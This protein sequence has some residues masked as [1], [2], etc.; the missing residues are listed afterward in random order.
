[1]PRFKGWERVRIDTVPGQV[2]TAPVIVSASRATDIPAWYPEWL[3]EGLKR[4][5]IRWNNPFSGREAYISFEK[6][7]AFVLW[8]KNPAPLIPYLPVLDRMGIQF[9]FQFTLNDY[10]RERLEPNVPSLKERISIFKKLSGLLGADRMI[11]RFDPLILSDS[12][13][14]D[15]LAERVRKVADEIHSYTRRLVISFVD[16]ERYK[17]VKI[18]LE[19]FGIYREF[20]L[21]EKHD[22]AERLGEMN[23][24]WDLSIHTCAEDID[25]ERFGIYKGHCIDSSLL[26]RLFPDDQ[27][28]AEFFGV[29]G[30]SDPDGGSR[31]IPGMMKD[32]GQRAQCGC[33]VAKDIGQY[34][35]CM[36]LCTYCYANVSEIIVRQN[37][38]RYRAQK[39]RGLFSETIVPTYREEKPSPD[40]SDGAANLLKD[41]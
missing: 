26:L 35:T 27:A 9:Y 18:H 25:L 8:S 6:A 4:G 38:M 28:L 11:W 13:T 32:P 36:H 3:I 1:M 10:E 30:F 37:Y 40:L 21:E 12:I 34:C 22:L 17:N 23:K 5:Y 39:D 20:T 15:D 41:Q 31:V 33:T 24:E 14:I 29:K 19:R 2:A 7:R 16:I